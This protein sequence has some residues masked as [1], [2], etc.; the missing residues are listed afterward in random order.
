MMAGRAGFE[1]IAIATTELFVGSHAKAALPDMLRLVERWRPDVVVRETAE[2]ASLVA[3]EAHGIPD[4]RVGIA[5]ATPYEDW[6]LAMASGALDALREQAGVPGDPGADRA[7]RAPVMTQVP[8]R[9]RRAPGRAAG[10]RAPLPRA[11]AA[12]RGTAARTGGGRRRRRSCRCPS[13]PSSRP[14]GTTRASTAR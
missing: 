4:V 1:R 8:V 2:V 10:V 13:A 11:G 6:W 12:D 14:T 7:R 5:L 9:A 3:A